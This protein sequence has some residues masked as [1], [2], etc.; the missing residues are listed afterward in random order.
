MSFT[1]M[2]LC[3]F[4]NEN[5]NDIINKSIAKKPFF[6]AA[7]VASKQQWQENCPSDVAIFDLIELKNIK[8]RNR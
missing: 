5:S 2:F 3:S 6:T 4:V 7:V 1:A 8:N